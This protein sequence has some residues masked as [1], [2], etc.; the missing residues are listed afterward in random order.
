MNYL[1]GTLCELGI[2]FVLEPVIPKNT[3]GK[4]PSNNSVCVHNGELLESIRLTDY[5]YY[6]IHNKDICKYIVN[7]YPC[8]SIT[9]I[10]FK[11]KETVVSPMET[12]LNHPSFGQFI[13]Y[14]DIRLVSWN[15]KLY[16]FGSLTGLTDGVI[17]P[18]IVEYGD[19]SP[20]HITIFHTGNNEK[21]WM[22]ITD[23]P[24]QFMYDPLGCSVMDLSESK[25][26]LKPPDE[27]KV[28]IIKPCKFS[29]K[30]SGSSQ[31][32]PIEIDGIKKYIG[33]CHK[34]YQW[35]DASGFPHI[36]YD[37]FFIT[38]NEYLKEPILSQPFQFMINGI[39]FCCGICE[40]N[41]TII[42][43]FSI[44]D[45]LPHK[46][47]IPKND[48]IGL[49]KSNTFSSKPTS[50]DFFKEHFEKI[51]K[52]STLPQKIQCIP[53]I[54]SNIIKPEDFDDEQN[55]LPNGI[56]RKML[57]NKYLE[58]SNIQKLKRII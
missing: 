13:G 33:I 46:L 19:L 42:I 57:I 28:N 58:S 50:C 37:H 20:Q 11:D 8:N 23:K 29:G 38:Y 36:R 32:I 21:N 9:I 1:I 51:Y 5:I 14:E 24:F 27:Y 4:F 41:D 53:F 26:S 15:N 40:Y 17:E 10:H 7:K 39:E 47:I 49:L 2:P 52:E 31:L 12:H 18:T 54:D 16:S 35:L 48:F 44:I 3:H 45:G 6:P 30:I 25:F 56:L 22:P 34:R 43:S 55:I